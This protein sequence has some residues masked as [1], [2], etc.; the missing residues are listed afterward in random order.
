MSHLGSQVSALVDGQLSAA[1]RD[2]ALAHVAV[3]G[4]CAA[5]MSSA[6]A[7]R[8]ALT[9][10]FDVPMAPELTQRLLALGATSGVARGAM[11]RDASR[12]AGFPQD[13]VPLPG[14]RSG[15]RMPDDCLHGDLSARWWAPGRW[16]AAVAAVAVATGA[17]F[18]LGGLPDVE[19]ETHPAQALTVLGRAGGAVTLPRR[20]PADGLSVQVGTAARSTQ[21]IS[22]GLVT[23]PA[24]PLGAGDAPTDAPDLTGPGAGERLDGWL[25]D[26]HW[27][28]CGPLPQGYRVA[29][30]RETPSGAGIEIDLDGDH[31]V[32]VVTQQK[33]RLSPQVVEA[34]TPAEVSGT[35]VHLLSRAPWH[36][37]WQSGDV[38]VSVVAEIESPALSAV[39]AAHPSVP[40][41]DGVVARIARGWSALAGTWRP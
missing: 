28:P 37:V 10:A 34:A 39:A 3:C 26:H 4:E 5:E 40:V 31:G 17:L 33:G 15:S 11:Q 41:D 1:A 9:G 20:A 14:T 18:T 21:R 7:A 13:S 6:R 35:S 24:V 32:V 23:G 36:A 2:R 25:R 22:A 12:P 19:P 27:A 38:V 30:L 16:L 29:A 8:R